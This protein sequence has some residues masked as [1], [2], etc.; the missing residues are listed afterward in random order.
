MVSNNMRL[1]RAL[2]KSNLQVIMETNRM[3]S[4][5]INNVANFVLADLK[6][7]P[8]R[9]HVMVPHYFALG[10]HASGL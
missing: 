6:Y 7:G 4:G 9:A 3:L 5:K 1:I 8:S 2:L 10:Q